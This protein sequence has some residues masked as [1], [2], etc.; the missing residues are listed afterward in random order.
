M[1]QF[2]LTQDEVASRTGKDRATVANSVR[3]LS[4]EQ[5]LLEWIEEGKITAGHGRALLAVEDRKLRNDLALQ[6]SRGK[7]TVRQLEKMATRR[8]RGRVQP[9][10]TIT[11]DPNRQAA[12]DELQK[13]IGTRVT[14]HMPSKGH[15]G[16]LMLE[17]YDEEQLNGLYE[18]LMK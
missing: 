18:R 4:L 14:L 8:S 1:E 15:A 12:L 2:H 13:H 5:P 7:L 3:L 17:F 9:A 16:Q 6:A 11:H 10:Q